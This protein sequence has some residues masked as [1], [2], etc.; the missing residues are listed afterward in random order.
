MERLG[1]A[2]VVQQSYENVLADFYSQPRKLA[3]GGTF[4]DVDFGCSVSRE[5]GRYL[6]DLVVAI[7]PTTVLEIGLAWGGSAVHICCALRDNGRGQNTALDPFQ[8][9]IW[10]NVAL[11]ELMR[12]GLDRT[13]SFVE[14]RSDLFLPQLI[15]ENRSFDIVF[16]DGN[17]SLSG[18]FVDWHYCTRLLRVGGTVVFDDMDSE[19]MLFMRRYI[20][21]NDRHMSCKGM[22][23]GRFIAYE[24]LREGP[25]G[26]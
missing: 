13:F 26:S 21:E 15:R 17:H 24:K 10:G 6:Y 20:E 18:V 19:P 22:H 7:Q 3:A 8:T 11:N 9:L 1:G 16:I 14:D 12:L 2:P 25:V 4:R 5:Q 23:Q